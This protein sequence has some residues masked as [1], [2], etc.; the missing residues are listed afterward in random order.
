MKGI[1]AAVEGFLDQLPRVK[2]KVKVWEAVD[3]WSA[4]IETSGK[5]Q[6]EKITGGVLFV[7]TESPSLGQE[8]ALKKN[9]FIKTMNAIT[10][11]ETVKDIKVRIGSITGNG[12]KGINGKEKRL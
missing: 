5:S 9:S 4:K 7:V 10:G 3:I 6:A 1:K 2:K 11:E 12:G 8:I